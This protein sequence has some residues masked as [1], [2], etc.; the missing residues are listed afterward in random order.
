MSIAKTTLLSHIFN[1]EYLLPFWLHHHK[2]MFDEIV[3]IDYKSTDKSIEICKSICPE[4]KIIQ[5]RNDLF[6]AHEVDREIMDI[7]NTI[8]GIKLVLN[9]TEFLFCEN[10]AKDMFIDTVEPTSYYIRAISPYSF[11]HYNIT[12]NYD[13]FYNLLQNEVVYHYDRPGARY[14]HNFPNGNYHIGRHYTHNNT[15]MTNKA[16][17]VWFGFYPMNDNLLKRKL[18]IQQKVPQHDK[19]VGWGIQH[20]YTKDKMLDINNS[21]STSGKPLREINLSLYNLLSSK[22]LA[23]QIKVEKEKGDKEEDEEKSKE[24]EEVVAQLK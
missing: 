9:T 16:H 19:D 2:D 6:G 22:Y 21:K 4:C 7:E 18:Q 20:L 1:E 12:N 24:D 15:I 11:D 17:I 13:L 3:I 23:A 5:T 14:L 10:T 8:E